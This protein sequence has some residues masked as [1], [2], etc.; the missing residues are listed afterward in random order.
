MSDDKSKTG[1]DGALV[2]LT[3][4]Y[5]IRDWCKS[6][7]CTE[8]ELREAVRVAGNSSTEVRAYLAKRG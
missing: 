3:E 6:L 4:D 5:E 7:G 2:S 1:A 8:A